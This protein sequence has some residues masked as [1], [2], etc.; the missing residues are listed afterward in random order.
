M[1]DVPRDNPQEKA[2]AF[3]MRL[4]QSIKKTTWNIYLSKSPPRRLLIRRRELF[5]VL[6]LV[7]SCLIT[8]VLLFVYGIPTNPVDN[9]NILADG[10]FFASPGIMR[11]G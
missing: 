9:N 2:T 6:P 4:R 7:L 10:R 1:F 3:F 8:L 5:D 11:Q